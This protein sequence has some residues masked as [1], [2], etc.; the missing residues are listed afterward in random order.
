MNIAKVNE[1]LN[2]VRLRLESLDPRNAEEGI[3]TMSAGT[4][5]GLPQAHARL[6]NL[7][8]KLTSGRSEKNRIKATGTKGRK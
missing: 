5:Q 2:K 6:A 1:N 8:S 7:M 4:N 3:E